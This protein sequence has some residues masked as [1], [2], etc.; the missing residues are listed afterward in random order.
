MAA[1]LGRRSSTLGVLALALSILINALLLFKLE[2]T[3]KPSSDK[4]RTAAA[5]ETKPPLSEKKH[6][7][8]QGC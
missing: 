8:F 4:V 3:Y 7:F 1:E 5:P 2:Y 6:I